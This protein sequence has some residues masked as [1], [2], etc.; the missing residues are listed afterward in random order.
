MYC[1]AEMNMSRCT[2][3]TALTATVPL[4]SSLMGR[5]VYLPTETVPGRQV[6]LTAEILP[7]RQVYL[8]AERL[9][10]RQVYLMAE[11]LPRRQVYLTIETLPERQVYLMAEML[12]GRQVYLTIETLLERQI[13][14]L[15]EMSMA[16][17]MLRRALNKLIDRAH[18][19]YLIVGVAEVPLGREERAQVDD[20]HGAAYM[21]GSKKRFRIALGLRHK[22]QNGGL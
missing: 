9:P 13:Y 19:K 1:P 20:E 12:P 6:Y 2:E 21:A 17:S 11:M 7:G 8:M 10:G 22:R 18:S 4:P 5:R 15:A 14:L 3:T 16:R